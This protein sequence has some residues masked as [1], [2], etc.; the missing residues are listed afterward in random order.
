MDP[1]LVFVTKT[2]SLH[3]KQFLASVVWIFLNAV[4]LFKIIESLLYI[5]NMCKKFYL[6]SPIIR[7]HN[8][9]RAHRI[10]VRASRA[11]PTWD[12]CQGIPVVHHELLHG[13]QGIVADLLV[14]MVHVV[15]HQLLSTKLL[16]NPAE[17]KRPWRY[18]FFQ[19]YAGHTWKVQISKAQRISK[20]KATDNCSKL[21]LALTSLSM[22]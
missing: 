5:S 22:S 14:F 16:N 6:K 20:T 18:H 7:W 13:Q 1:T 3:L 9:I 17:Q 15:H 8:C 12:R 19:T 2:I 10:N 4:H 21:A 11:M